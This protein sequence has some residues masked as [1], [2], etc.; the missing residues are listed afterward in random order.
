MDPEP[1]CCQICFENIILQL[2]ELWTYFDK[3]CV[4]NSKLCPVCSVEIKPE[5]P[6]HNLSIY[7]IIIVIMNMNMNMNKNHNCKFYDLF[8]L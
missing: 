2:L 5:F 8:G 4:Q 3:D 6:P 7:F 1:D